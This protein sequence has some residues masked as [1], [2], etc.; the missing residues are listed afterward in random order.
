MLDFGLLLDFG[1][2]LQLALDSFRTRRILACRFAR[3]TGVF[4][5]AVR[6]GVALCAF[7]PPLAVGARAAHRAVVFHLAVGA[8]GALRTVVL[9]LAVGAGGAHRTFVFQFAVMAGVE[10]RA[11]V[12]SLP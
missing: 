8:G 12:F 7:D 4:Q 2:T 5:L 1:R 3:R 10:Q 6:T 9:H 11:V